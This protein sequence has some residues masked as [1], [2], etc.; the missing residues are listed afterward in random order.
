MQACH[1]GLGF[2]TKGS[3]LGQMLPGVLALLLQPTWPCF[4][5]GD[6]LAHFCSD[7][8]SLWVWLHCCLSL[9]PI[10]HSNICYLNQ[11]LWPHSWAPSV[12]PLNF[13]HHGG[14]GGWKLESKGNGL[15]ATFTDI[16]RLCSNVFVGLVGHVPMVGRTEWPYIGQAFWFQATEFM[17]V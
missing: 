4:S 7:L 11:V 5:D 16:G 17:C 14:N 3:W 13:S 15:A 8:R 12:W 10:Q 6:S 2:F 9:S 1:R